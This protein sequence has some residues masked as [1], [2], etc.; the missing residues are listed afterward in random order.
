MP[1]WQVIII[2]KIETTHEMS[3][4]VGGV[5]GD[6]QS[7]CW[8]CLWLGVRVMIRVRLPPMLVRILNHFIRHGEEALCN[9][10]D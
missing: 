9:G 7:G 1:S 2:I 4:R 6:L 5:I 8:L 10:T 3:N